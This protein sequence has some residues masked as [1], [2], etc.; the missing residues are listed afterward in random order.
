LNQSDRHPDLEPIVRGSTY[1]KLFDWLY[2]AAQLRYTTKDHLNRLNHQFGTKKKIQSLI[3]AGFLTAINS[4]QVFV[5]TDKTR[6]ALK[7]EGY[8]TKILQKEFNGSSVEH[9]LKIVDALFETTLANPEL[10]AIFY[11]DFGYVRP[12]AIVVLKKPGAYKIV[13][14]EVE[15]KKDQW[16]NYLQNKKNNYCRL[17]EDKDIYEKWWKVWS[18]KLNLPYPKKEDFCFWIV[19]CTDTK[20]KWE[21]WGLFEGRNFDVSG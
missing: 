8:N 17:A 10:H 7:D 19:A 12:D 18:D 2:K 1:K 6:Q 13:F 4:N 14:L 16:E 3:E 11:Y 9:E 20:G 15:E 5:I 21:G